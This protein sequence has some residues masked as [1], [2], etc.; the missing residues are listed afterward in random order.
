MSMGE[1]V[2]RP[3]IRVTWQKSLVDEEER[4]GCRIED[5]LEVVA[6]KIKAYQAG[7]LA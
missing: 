1:T 2:E 7:P 5:V 4:N 3:F 6:D